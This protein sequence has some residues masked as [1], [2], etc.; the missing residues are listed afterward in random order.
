MTTSSL[1]ALSTP[2]LTL[3]HAIKR[4]FAS[5]PTLQAVAVKVLQDKLG[6]RYR[7]LT[8][9]PQQPM[10]MEPVYA[11]SDKGSS[12][13]GYNSLTL[14]DA[15]IERCVSGLFVDYSKG[16]LLVQHA[17]AGTPVPLSVSSSDLEQVINEAGDSLIQ[18]YQE[19]LVDYWM[20]PGTDGKV[21]YLWLADALKNLLLVIAG[22]STVS[23]AHLD[24]IIDVVSQP[25]PVAGK[26]RDVQAYIVDQWGESGAINLELLRGLVLVKQRGD[27]TSVL[28]FTL[29]WGI[30]VFDSLDKLGER[31]VSLLSDIAPDHHMQWRLCQPTGNI[32]HS[33]SLTFLAKQL[34][35]IQAVI[36]AVRAFDNQQRLLERALRVITG[37]FDSAPYDT[38]DMARLRAALPAWL[39]QADTDSQA[40]MS[41]YA[42]DLARPMREPGWKP[43]DDGIPPASEFAS[44]TLA[45]Q[46]AK[47]HPDKPPVDPDRIKVLMN[48]TDPAPD[49]RA[50]AF[51]HVPPLYTQ[52][53][54]TL[55][56]FAWLGATDIDPHLL[57]L[58]A[59]EPDDPVPWLTP[60]QVVSAIER[61]DI[62]AAYRRLIAAKL[63]DDPAEVSWRKAR[64]IEQLRLQ[65]PMLALEYHL[66]Y[67]NAFSR[68]AYDSVVAV[69]NTKEAGQGIVLRP[70]AFKLMP[71]SR[72]DVVHNIFV[73]GPREVS[74]GPHLLYRPMA[75]VKLIE[76]ASWERLLSAIAHPGPLQYQV[77]AWLPEAVRSRYLKPGLAAPGREAFEWVD[78]QDSVWADGAV[79]LAQEVVAGDYLEQL[80]AS[81]VEAM[82]GVAPAQPTTGLEM[83]W[84][85][86]K[87]YFG[88]GLA[89]ILPLVGGPV[90]QVAGWLL[91]AWLSWQDLKEIATGTSQ[92]KLSGVIDLLVNIA[93]LLL[94]RGRVSTNLGATVAADTLLD[95]AQGRQLEETLEL[96]WHEAPEVLLE[97]GQTSRV[98][99]PQVQLPSVQSSSSLV[100]SSLQLEQT[101][102]GLYR[103]LSVIRRAELALY[104]VRVPPHARRIDAGSHRGLYSA[105]GSLY[106]SVD[107]DWFKVEDH[108]GV[109][110]V[111]N[112][113][114]AQRVGPGLTYR[115]PGEWSFSSEP[116]QP[117]DYQQALVQERQRLAQ[118][119]DDEHRREDLNAEYEKLLAMFNIQTFTDG[120][121]LEGINLRFGDAGSDKVFEDELYK[122]DVTRWCAV[123][124]LDALQRRR[125]LML[126]ADYAALY[127]KFSASAVK[128]R[129]NQALLYSGQLH[130]KLKE[131]KLAVTL[132][133]AQNMERI[134]LDDSTW[135]QTAPSLPDLATLGAKAIDACQEAEL[136]LSQM[137]QQ[138]K[139]ADAAVVELDVPAWAGR[140]MSLKWQELQ[141][142]TLALLCFKAG[143]SCFKDGIFDLIQEVTSLCSVKLLSRR[144]L[145]TR[146]LFNWDQRLR[147][148]NDTLDA[149]VLADCRLSYQLG[150]LPAYIDN[151]ALGTYR[152]SIRS[153]LKTLEFELIDAYQQYERA[154]LATVSSK[155]A[156]G[157]KR[158]IEV[159]LVGRVIG[160]VR[161][162]TEQGEAR[163]YL[164]IHEP[165]DH[166]SVCSFRRL[167]DEVEAV[168]QAVPPPS[169][170]FG[171]SV[172]V[173]ERLSIIGGEAN[174]LWREAQ[175]K[176]EQIA[177]LE[178]I[179]RMSPERVRSEWSHYANRMIAQR[180]LLI[181][182]LKE[183][184][185]SAK[186]RALLDFFKNTPSALYDEI[187]RFI[188]QGSL[189]RNR[190]ILQ[191]PPTSDGLLTLYKAWM[192]DVIEVSAQ[193]PLVRQFDIRERSTGRSL[194]RA[195]FHYE[196]AAAREVGFHYSR[197]NLKRYAERD[198]SYAKLKHRAPNNEFMINVLR[199]NID[200]EVAE[201]VFFTEDVK[202]LAQ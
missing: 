189:A 195:R 52:S 73:I 42:I 83:F 128:A 110:H 200:H 129:R 145:F 46:L 119:A 178:T 33:F 123:T 115:E 95:L 67:P 152:S 77:L 180:D 101:W 186:H 162:V 166:R 113:D 65:L 147:V 98:A 63:I 108:G 41:Q 163:E 2:S 79:T 25:H 109:V 30:E 182:A 85:W 127:S 74:G 160:N 149:L 16:Q 144:Q 48:V 118:L 161:K 68:K 139:V 17:Q 78:F 183:P 19:A 112:E 43:F 11:Y 55:T 20:E 192:I 102:S 196:T 130:L 114:T 104:E 167:G 175:Q 120:E 193:Q 116:A 32:F 187:L 53:T 138:G 173:H 142:R 137:M 12:L 194:W 72:A 23:H 60:E 97:G 164:D 5:R 122:A 188:E 70:L 31:L 170:L 51:W 28:L 117:E 44:R 133:D 89:L 69:L 131:N 49:I 9:D 103:R 106:A 191:G 169:P 202:P 176:F 27:K 124:L 155:L 185:A 29:S 90:G 198:I 107:G 171:S 94:S 15:L 99:T 140:R 165:F 34:A 151:W 154:D 105:G 100:R 24:M 57:S 59:L 156:S 143:S 179:S 45:A 8:I 54:W 22:G 121:T 14:V 96:S 6:R 159:A 157:S 1:P 153:L 199:T 177:S 172:A 66:R 61:A 13:Q 201:A 36:P 190:M 80:F 111:V 50:K 93:L 146:G 84:D 148:L 64:F 3:A 136:R 4:Y 81:N 126:V 82:A 86:V 141:L 26:T 135:R 71:E 7:W 184:P 158:L 58:A 197:G 125:K 35:D 39:L 87:R 92:D 10:L 40:L 38:S 88:L 132:L 76:F 174:R 56:R 75:S 21:R 168:W 91:L 37:D 181:D 134:V 150:H 18:L 62:G 47:D